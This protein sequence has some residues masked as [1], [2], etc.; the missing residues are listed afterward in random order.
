MKFLKL[1][2]MLLAV[3]AL[4]LVT[5]YGSS[6][7]SQ[8]VRITN[9]VVAGGP[10]KFMEVRHIKIKGSNFEIGKAI[11][12]IAQK[13][14]IKMLPSG[15]PKINRAKREYLAD[16]YPVFYERMRGV[17]ET[18]NL[19][20]KNNEFNFSGISQK[21]VRPFGC[22]AVYY[23]AEYTE[24]GHSLMS[25][26]Y[27]FSTGDVRGKPVKNGRLPAMSRPCIFEFYPD[28][29]YASI[30]VT[31]FDYLSGSMDGI[32]SEGLTVTVLSDGET[33]A[34]RGIHP[35][36]EPGIHELLC[37]RYLLDNCKDAPEAKKALLSLHHYMSTHP[38]HYIVGDRY[39]NSFIFEF[40]L[41]RD[42]KHILDNKGP[43]CV[44]NHLVH[45]HKDLER[46]RGM[47]SFDRFMMLDEAAGEKKTFSINEI[48]TISKKAAYP[49]FG[50][51]P[52]G[53]APHRTLW[54]ALYDTNDSSVEIKFYMGERPNPE[55]KNKPVIEY[56]EPVKFK[57]ER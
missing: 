22:S 16:K 5:F 36:N 37:M 39:G 33:I 14:G 43:Q 32:N 18:Y 8:T 12:R 52:P 54:Y 55:D 13:K 6:G 26:N 19:D 57:L 24:T 56:T 21:T 35:T 2:Q 45:R 3:A 27:D 47:D 1:K 38:C 7:N 44:T 28:K 15:D 50:V 29:G 42:K 11:G 9:H 41:D 17:A 48:R 49:P 25:R 4:F 20:I 23:P 31:V 51:M 34:L 46:F 10:D 53:Y 30:A 40:S